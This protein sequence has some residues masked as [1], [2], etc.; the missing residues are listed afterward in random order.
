MAKPPK[1][2]HIH[3]GI[4]AEDTKGRNMR[5]VGDRLLTS[6]INVGGVVEKSALL[7]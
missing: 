3:C 7:Y 4:E 1:V 5:D 2:P 6:V